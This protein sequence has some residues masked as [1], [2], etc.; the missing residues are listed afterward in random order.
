MPAVLRNRR[1]VTARGGATL[2]TVLAALLLTATACGGG[3][4]PA[5]RS[6]VPG[7]SS[8]V[9]LSE[10]QEEF[11]V[12]EPC[13][14]PFP[15]QVAPADLTEVTLWPTNFPEPPVAAVLCQA[16]ETPDGTIATVDYATE[17]PPEQVLATYRAALKGL[18][19]DSGENPDEI[20]GTAADGTRFTIT[21]PEGTIKLAFATE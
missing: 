19:L 12:P 7:G 8:E 16:F 17:T 15:S 13:R 9:D 5:A 6:E 4:D 10:V 20:N 1:P 2:G 14:E 21:A 3:D 11:D 18:E